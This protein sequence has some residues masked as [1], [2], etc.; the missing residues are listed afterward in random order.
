MLP[1]LGEEARAY[2]TDAFNR[3]MDTT[4]PDAT[5]SWDAHTAKG[6]IRTGA[7][8]VSKSRATCRPY[9]ESYAVG[10]TSGT[11]EG[12]ACKR[13]ANEGWCRLKQ[14]NALTCALE[15]TQD[16]VEKT[17]GDVKSWLGF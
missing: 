15:H 5:Y 17:L 3:A 14:G 13:D 4:A 1:L 8:F 16:P 6:S 2:Y 10:K 12:I 9:S 7:R 11:N